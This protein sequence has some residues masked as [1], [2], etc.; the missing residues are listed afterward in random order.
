MK[1]VC[2]VTS[3]HKYNDVRILKKECASLA[4]KYN[5]IL[6]APN[7]ESGIYDGVTVR[8]VTLPKNRL[9]RLFKLKK[10]YEVLEEVNADVYH[11]HDPELMRMGLWV[12]KRLN[13]KVIFDSHE[14]IPLD[15]A[16]KKWIPSLLRPLVSFYFDYYEK[17]ALAKYDGLISVT[18][19]IVNKLKKINTNTYQITNYPIYSEVEDKRKWGD[20]I[21]FAGLVNGN[22]MHEN[23]IDSLTGLNIR[24]ELAGPGPE[25][26]IDKL[27]KRENWD[28][29]D[30]QGEKEPHTIPEFL[31]ESSIGIALYDYL[32]SFGYKTGSLGNNKIFEYM[33]AGIP[34]IATDFTLWKEIIEDQGCGVCVDPHDVSAISNAILL[35]IS[36]KDRA[37]LMGDTGRVLVKTK[38]NWSSQEPVLYELYRSLLLE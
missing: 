21:C 1:T 35:L 11:F 28:K 33:A 3:V 29:V 16:E 26:Y 14:D 6:V 18:P 25:L 30:Y 7:V 2:H 27:K 22:W 34:I 12:K 4:H 17:Y 20:S 19:T 23:I 32:P 36:D 9:R 38:Y 8:G 15:M 31:Q 5:V 37:K 24:Y 13:K 10:V